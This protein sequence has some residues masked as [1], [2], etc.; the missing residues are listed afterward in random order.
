MLSTTPIRHIWFVA[1]LLLVVAFASGWPAVQAQTTPTVQLAGTLQIVW[2]DA[3]PPQHTA[4]PPLY[5]LVDA[6]GQKTELIPTETRGASRSNFGTLRNQHVTVTGQRVGARVHVSTITTAAQQNATTAATPTGVSG[7][8][9]WIT[10]LCRFADVAATPHPR[11]YYEALMS[12]TYPGV[13]HYWR[14]TS[15]NTMNL[16][17]SR[18]VGW[19]TLPRSQAY[20]EEG[21]MYERIGRISKDC[22]AAA[23]A[24]VFFPSF[25]GINL[26]FNVD[27]LGG[28]AF[29]TEG[30]TVFVDGDYR[31]FPTTWMPAPWLTQHI[32]AHEMGHG[33]GLPHSSGPYDSTYDSEWDVMSGG[34]TCNP[35]NESN[36]YGC[37]GVHTIA[38]HKDLLGWIPAA[39]KY[40]ASA[41][42]TQQIT[43]APLAA[44]APAGTHLMAQIPLNGSTTQFYTVESRRYVG[45]DR[46]VPR[47]AIL[48]HHVD[49]MRWDRQAQVV[50]VDNNGAINDAGTIWLPGETFRDDANNVVISIDRATATGVAVTITSTQPPCADSAYEPD[51]TQ[52]QARPF[53]VGTTQR[54]AFCALYDEDWV[55][56]EATAGRTYRIETLNIAP[57]TDP[58][59]EL[60]ADRIMFNDG[61]NGGAA[62]LIIFKPTRTGTYALVVRQLSGDG[63]TASGYD[64]R[65]TIDGA[66]LLQPQVHIP[67]IAR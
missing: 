13:D 24:D 41:S 8:Q 44:P 65:I 47:E 64:L 61:G 12:N 9:P 27:V 54:R 26:I 35:F 52:A 3:L 48:I 66:S 30:E 39:N 5:V 40:L 49:T 59:L 34:S 29:G 19:Y 11:S 10:I 18:V 1:A 67:L 57:G 50:D 37:I 56:F 31:Q 14:E 21:E 23:D 15:Y 38:Y 62:D 28:Y 17:G 4:L 2:R 25:V 55:T 36:E 16:S 22:T 7:A 63:S 32:V 58:Y 20:Y 43:I 6:Q 60:H 53:L 46:R 45:Y 51:D 42:G 33:Y